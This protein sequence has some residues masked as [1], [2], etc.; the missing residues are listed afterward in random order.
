MNRRWGPC[1]HCGAEGW[2][3]VGQ[4]VGGLFDHDRPDGKKCRKAEEDRKKGKQ[5]AP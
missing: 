5:D 1:P 4:K 2:E 3:A